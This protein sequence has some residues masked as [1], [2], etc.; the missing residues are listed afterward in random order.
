MDTAMVDAFHALLS[1][2]AVTHFSSSMYERLGGK[3]SLLVSSTV[4]NISSGSG[5]GVHCHT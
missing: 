3:H 4:A 5:A 1:S 2:D